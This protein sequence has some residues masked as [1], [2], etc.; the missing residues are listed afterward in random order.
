M[1]KSYTTLLIRMIVIGQKLMRASIIE[2]RVYMHNIC[3]GSS[4]NSPWFETKIKLT[5]NAE[6]IEIVTSR[7]AL[8][9]LHNI[10]KHE[11]TSVNTIIPVQ[12]QTRARGPADWTVEN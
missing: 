4:R 1:A 5:F 6:G 11:V 9:N 3:I 8:F 10:W 2:Q 12:F 7:S